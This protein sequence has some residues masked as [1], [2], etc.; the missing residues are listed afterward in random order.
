MRPEAR[1]EVLGMTSDDARR[2]ASLL[3]KFRHALA[4]ERRFRDMLLRA[5]NDPTVIERIKSIAKDG[6]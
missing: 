4:V 6:S 2:A 3:V 1:R 5:L